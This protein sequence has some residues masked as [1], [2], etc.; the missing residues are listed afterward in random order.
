MS[1]EDRHGDP[2]GEFI[3]T[4]LDMNGIDGL[5][6]ATIA[7]QVRTI[8]RS[9]PADVT[10]DLWNERLDSLQ[11]VIRV[12]L[13]LETVL[14]AFEQRPD[15]AGF[16][17]DDL[18]TLIM[19]SVTFAY[20]SYN[21]LH[22]SYN[23]GEAHPQDNTLVARRLRDTLKVT[24]GWV[25]RAAREGDPVAAKLVSEINALLNVSDHLE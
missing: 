21:Q 22:T 19:L 5:N 8:L 11:A 1:D 10:P 17:R 12:C 2:F 20:V 6:P 4:S 14:G 16:T 25:R 13:D 9:L 15:T 3:N 7:E 18:E 24:L 23:L